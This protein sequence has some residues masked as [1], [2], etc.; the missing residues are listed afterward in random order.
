MQMRNDTRSHKA[1][2]Y[3]AV[4]RKLAHC[5]LEEHATHTPAFLDI[6]IAIFSLKYIHFPLAIQTIAYNLCTY[7][8]P[9]MNSEIFLV[10]TVEY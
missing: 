1:A 2:S 5:L 9:D 7:V 3:A 10:Y 8:K 4:S 6:A